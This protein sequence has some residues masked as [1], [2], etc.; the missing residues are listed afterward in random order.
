[1]LIIK[2]DLYK[3]ETFVH[4]FYEVFRILKFNIWGKI[5]YILV[6]NCGLLLLCFVCSF[7]VWGI[8]YFE[9]R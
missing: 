5:K 7:I 1:M 3:N 9:W 8:R 6:R 4:R 2:S